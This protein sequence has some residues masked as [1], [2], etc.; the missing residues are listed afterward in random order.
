M[1]S[2]S[3]PGIGSGLDI[4]N[5][6][7]S[8]VRAEGEPVVQ[9]L[10][11]R[12][13]RVEAQLSAIGSLKSALSSFKTSLLDVSTFNSFA[14]R[15]ASSSN[16][17]LFSATAGST[18]T[19]ATYQLEV[20]QLA[21]AH[22][23]ATGSFEDSKASI[24][25]GTL[26]FQYGDPSKPAQTVT[27]EPG[28]GSL[29]GIRDAVNNAGIEVSASIIKGDDGYQLVFSARGTGVDNSI[30]I[31]VS[32]NPANGG[33]TDMN[34]LSQ[35]AYNPDAEV[36][37]GRNLNQMTEAKDAIAHI[38]GIRVTSASNTLNNSI[39]GVS[40]TLQKA[41]SGSPATLT[42][43]ADRASASSGVEKFVEGFN[44]LAA[45]FKELGGYDAASQTGGVLQGDATLRGVENQLRRMISNVVPG[46]DGAYRSMADIGIRTQADGSL[47]LD[48]A[49]LEQ[50][51]SQNF[52]DIARIFAAAGSSQDSL[53]R[54][55]GASS[56]T[57]PG[58]YAVNVTQLATQGLYR[59]VAAQL[60]SLTVG[61]DNDSFRIKVNGI[62]SGLITLNRASYEDGHALAA[63]LQSKING[64]GN[65]SAARTTVKVSFEDGAFTFR[66]ERYGSVSQVAISS[67][68]DATASALIGLTANSAASIAGLDVAGTIGGR[69]ATGSGQTLIGAGM[70]EGLRIE[71]AG[72][73]LGDRGRMSFSRGVA[74]QMN[75]MLDQFLGDN[76]FLT[77]RTDSLDSQL[78]TIGDERENLI[79]RMDSLEARYMR[80]FSALDAM[81]AQMQSTSNFLAGQL[82]AL[83]GA[84]N[85]RN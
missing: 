25:T 79:R 58:S 24:G 33:N 38:D 60:S 18:A 74:D 29:E 67:V 14:R 62:Q 85:G 20:E 81:M 80:Q 22:K 64:D 34:G 78:K 23:L 2:I 77:A 84:Y 56:N 76:S 12:Q 72:G 45:L 30:R 43:A 71:V 63:E 36:G 54:Y 59:D 8:L 47:S 13:E 26:T 50:A 52:D 66:S 75:T 68:K 21:V 35:L 49:R 9:R 73:E 28:Q 70:A 4:R 53:M 39:P 46:L 42:V 57:Q 17:S 5:L 65:L 82:T 19:P 61:A 10:D 27:I 51:L 6:V 1:A 16:E 83:P 41:E 31:S 11:R 40:I 69:A 32:E 44:K 37:A 48:K 15:S 55:A 7:D 3:S